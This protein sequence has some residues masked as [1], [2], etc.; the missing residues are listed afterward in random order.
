MDTALLRSIRISNLLTYVSGVSSLMA[1][2]FAVQRRVS[3][4]GLCIGLSSLLDLL[5]GK[6]ANSFKRTPLEKKMG[7]EIDSLTDG[8]AFGFAPVVCLTIL[9]P[10]VASLLSAG[11]F[12]LMAALTRL[13]FYNVMSKDQDKTYFWGVPTTVIGMLWALW[14]L[15]PLLLPWTGVLFLAFGLMMILPIKV[16]RPS[17]KGLLILVLCLVVVILLHSFRISEV[18]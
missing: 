17:A 1:V 2:H 5:D 9:S 15:F 12:Y 4:V 11:G 8:V 14:L 3:A 18:Y 7:V 10:G 16:R 6:F 13:A